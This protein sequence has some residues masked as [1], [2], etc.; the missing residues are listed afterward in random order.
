MMNN[1]NIIIDG[2]SVDDCHQHGRSHPN[3]NTPS[4]QMFS[5][6]SGRTCTDTQAAAFSHADI[7]TLCGR[8]RW[9]MTC[10]YSQNVLVDAHSRHVGGCK[11]CSHLWEMFPTVTH[12]TFLSF[13][14]TVQLSGGEIIW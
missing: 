7:H 9:T 4:A 10:A 11:I 12:I 2:L 13:I 1:Y 3:T 8:C 14:I 6:L 5:S